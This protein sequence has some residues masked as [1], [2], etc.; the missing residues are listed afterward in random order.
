[1][2]RKAF[3]DTMGDPD[4]QAEMKQRFGV[5]ANPMPGEKV[6]K[7]FNEMEKTPRNIV[8]KVWKM[9]RPAKK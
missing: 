3:M 1:M 5:N 9:T 2:L 4:L 7:F 8:E 6:Q